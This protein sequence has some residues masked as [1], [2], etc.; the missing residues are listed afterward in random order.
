[1]TD[2]NI[3]IGDRIRDI[4]DGDCYYEGIWKGNNLYLCTKIIWNGLELNTPPI[5]ELINPNWW[6]IEK[7]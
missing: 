1:M 7:I 6:Y 5:N 2:L 4:E 3:N